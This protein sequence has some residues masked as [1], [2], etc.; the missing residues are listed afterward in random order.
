MTSRA[1]TLS[2]ALHGLLLALALVHPSA[3]WAPG[4]DEPN[5]RA[6]DSL[7]KALQTRTLSE[8]EFNQIVQTDK[9]LRAESAPQTNEDVFNSET[10][11]QVER[12]TRAARQGRFK[13]VLSEGTQ[14]AD[15][16]RIA[17]VQKLF[18]VGLPK[19][20]A[21][22]ET[23]TGETKPMRA[24]AAAGPQAGEGFSAT[25]DYLPHVAVAAN[26]LLNAREYKFYGFFERIREKLIHQW[27]R[28][29]RSELDNLWRQGVEGL[30][31]DRVTKV[32]VRLSK[33]G[34]VIGIQKTGSA[35]YTELDR[36]ATE[37]FYAASPFPNPPQELAEKDGSLSVDWHFVVVDQP[38]GGVQVKIRRVPAGF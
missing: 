37:A 18:D 4:S 31:G 29:L 8:S 9:R 38:G 2:L 16:A 25:D 32:R 17:K 33:I 19:D 28:R 24:P 34:E 15:T 3:P 7:A 36:A 23:A 1:W 6:Q 22:I 10:H 12:N 35:G 30:N 21:E 14:G 13:N 26:T 5:S 20:A 11:Q 27:E